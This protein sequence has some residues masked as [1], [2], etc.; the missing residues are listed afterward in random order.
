MTPTEQDM[1]RSL[2]YEIVHAKVHDCKDWFFKKTWFGCIEVDL[3]TMKVEVSDREGNDIELP[4]DSDELT[5]I[6][7]AMRDKM[8]EENEETERTYKILEQQF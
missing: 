4:I 1:I 6:Y 5:E 8:D 2:R 3:R 7:E